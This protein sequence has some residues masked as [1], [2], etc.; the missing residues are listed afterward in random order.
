MPNYRRNHLPG[1]TY[2][3]TVNLFEWKSRL[4][5]EHINELREAVR[6]VPDKHPF[7]FDTWVVLPDHRHPIS[8]LPAGGD[9]YSDRGR[10]IKKALTKA[11]PKPNIVPQQG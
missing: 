2:F 1:G 5:I 3:F 6:A 10:A 7:H 4:L 9:R 11:I 8:T